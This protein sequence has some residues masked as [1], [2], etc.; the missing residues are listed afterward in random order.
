IV[1]PFAIVTLFYLLSRR[2]PRVAFLVSPL[3]GIPLAAGVASI[4]YWPMYERHGYQFINEFFIQHHF[5]RFTSNKYQHPQP[6]YF[7][8][9]VL[10]LMTLPWMPFFL[11]NTWRQ[12]NSLIG[13][14]RGQDELAD[15]TD[16]ARRLRYFAWA[17]LLVPL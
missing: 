12:I 16:A 17:W 5:Q 1:F 15:E 10:P 13:R 7:F 8:L 4:W 2:M 11:F 9:W 3:W 14:L 6:F